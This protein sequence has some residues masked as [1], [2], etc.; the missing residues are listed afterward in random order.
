MGVLRT[1]F[2][3]DENGILVKILDKPKVKEH[4]SEI[5]AEFGL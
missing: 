2:L 3:I 4:A 1:T 5:A